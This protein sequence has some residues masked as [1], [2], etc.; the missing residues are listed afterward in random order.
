MLTYIEQ[1][2]TM[3]IEAETEL[4]A[5]ALQKWLDDNSNKT[6]GMSIDNLIAFKTDPY[7]APLGVS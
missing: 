2:G 6:I 1:D 4:E 3:H 7:N 5:Y